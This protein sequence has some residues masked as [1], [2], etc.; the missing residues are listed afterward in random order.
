MERAHGLT[1]SRR[2]QAALPGNGEL[3]AEA[4]ARTCRIGWQG[5]TSGVIP[6]NRRKISVYGGARGHA[7]AAL[8]RLAGRPHL[9]MYYCT[10]CKI[11]SDAVNLLFSF[12][13]SAPIVA[14][15][16]PLI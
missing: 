3:I 8:R 1:S 5:G 9:P 15:K 2:I 6:N 7:R 4:I 12:H 11:P 16:A 10:S 14:K 13:R